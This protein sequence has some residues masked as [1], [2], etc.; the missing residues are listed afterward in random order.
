MQSKVGINV[1]AALSGKYFGSAPDV[2]LIKWR[3]WD[4]TSLPRSRGMREMG[5]GL[6][7]TGLGVWLLK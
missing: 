7:R 4:E 1:P 3:F 5:I 6:R 2:L